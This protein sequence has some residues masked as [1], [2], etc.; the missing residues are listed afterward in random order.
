MIKNR[1]K[2]GLTCALYA[3]FSVAVW[4][5]WIHGQLERQARIGRDYKVT[6]EISHSK[7]CFFYVKYDQLTITNQCET[8]ILYQIASTPRRRM[9]TPHDFTEWHTKLIETGQIAKHRDLGSSQFSFT[10]LN[11]SK[12]YLTF[13][14]KH[15]LNLLKQFAHLSAH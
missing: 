12:C 5:E 7:K 8:G 10:Q 15:G 1:P 4:S 3:P 9:C 14:S 11:R 6:C 2:I 13:W